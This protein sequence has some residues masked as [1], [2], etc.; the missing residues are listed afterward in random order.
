MLSA[1][2]TI[3]ACED[4]EADSSTTETVEGILT[5]S[6]SPAADGCGY[7]LSIGDKIHKP[8]NEEDI[9]DSFMMV[10]QTPVEVKII[11]YHKKEDVVCGLS[12]SE[13]N[14]VKVL[15]LRKL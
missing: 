5:W 1:L 4:D 10:T 8:T 11:N 15:E 12:V 7:T 13:M 2:V 6:G 14:K 3:T 9:P